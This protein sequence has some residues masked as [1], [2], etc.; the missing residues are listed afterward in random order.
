MSCPSTLIL[1]SEGKRGGKGVFLPNLLPVCILGL[2]GSDRLPI[3]EPG[4]ANWLQMW[5]RPIMTGP[6]I[7]REVHFGGLTLVVTFSRRHCRRNWQTGSI[8]CCL[9]TTALIV[10]L[11]THTSCVCS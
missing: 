1:T 4:S 3:Y 7:A 10:F 11:P 2:L 6:C 8:Q 9:V 5:T